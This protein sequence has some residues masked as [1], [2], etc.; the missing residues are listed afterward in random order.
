MIIFNTITLIMS[1][2]GAS[3]TYVYALNTMNT[4]FVVIFAVEAALKLSGLGFKYYFHETWNKFDVFIVIISL[5]SLDSTLF[6][7]NFTALRIIRVARLLRMVRASKGLRHLLKTLYLALGNIFNVG[8]LLL[9]IFFVF[10]CAG[11][12]MYGTLPFGRNINQNANFQT[13]Y[14]A[15]ATL[16]RTA[17]GENWNYIMIDCYNSYGAFAIFYWIF[18]VILTHFVFINIFVAVVYEAFNDIKSS[19]DANEVLSLKRKD[20]KAFI[21]TWAYFNPDGSLYMKTR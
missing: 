5:I 16:L 15:M 17:T 10:A 1:F 13:F 12:D 8:A 18:Y 19:E 7:V 11:M 3:A 2:D 9:L 21:N 4:I 20:I 6:S 14:L